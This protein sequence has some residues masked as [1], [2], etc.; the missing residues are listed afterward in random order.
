MKRF[1]SFSRSS[2]FCLR[3]VLAILLTIG[4]A[5]GA[6]TAIAAEQQPVLVIDMNKVFEESISGKAAAANFE[7]E[8]KKRS[9]VILKMEAD[10]K[11][12]DEAI[13][14]QSSILSASAISEKREQF[15]KKRVEYSRLA[16]DAQREL[17]K[18]QQTEFEKVLRQIDDIAKVLAEK[19]KSRFVLDYDRRVVLYAKD[20][21]NLT[22]EIIEAL[23]ERSLKS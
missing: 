9:E 19:R 7:Q 21:I 8:K 16:Q 1:M 13:Q 6:R 17:M 12:L 22:S 23:D 20:T 18:F 3:S 5:V 10:L 2:L 14:K 4:S 15:E 11:K